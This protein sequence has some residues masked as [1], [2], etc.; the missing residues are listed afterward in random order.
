MRV[1]LIGAQ[2]HQRLGQRQDSSLDAVK[3]RRIVGFPRRALAS[4]PKC[5][6]SCA[7]GWG[8]WVGRDRPAARLA[9]VRAEVA[10]ERRTRA[11]ARASGLSAPRAAAAAAARAAVASPASIYINEA[12]LIAM[13]EAAAGVPAPCAKEAADGPGHQPRPAPCAAAAASHR[14]HRQLFVGSWRGRGSRGCRKAHRLP[15]LPLSAFRALHPRRRILRA[16]PFTHFLGTRVFFN[17]EERVPLI[18]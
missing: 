16:F 2:C 3:K 8:G 11:R 12:V 7:L 9:T 6:S 14:E 15:A 1:Y 5:W 13:A 10:R 18:T 17:T 4:R